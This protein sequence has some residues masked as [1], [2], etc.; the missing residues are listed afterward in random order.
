MP[1]S[2]DVNESSRCPTTPSPDTSVSAPAASAPCPPAGDHVVP[3]SPSRPDIVHDGDF[4]EFITFEFAP[5]PPQDSFAAVN[6]TVS[7]A[8]DPLDDF[9]KTQ[10]FRE[11]GLVDKRG[12]VCVLNL[13][14]TV[15]HAPYCPYTT[16]LDAPCHSPLAVQA[17]SPHQVMVPAVVDQPLSIQSVQQLLDLLV[18][19]TSLPLHAS[20][21]APSADVAHKT[22]CAMAD[23]QAQARQSTPL[24]SPDRGPATLTSSDT[25]IID[26]L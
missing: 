19:S 25:S 4:D 22:T 8:A 2:D 26:W 12:G 7:Q 1:P 23:L 9:L 3:Y 14:C 20:S 21:A 13:D 16:V 24:P 10:H 11:A 5:S 6:N 18:G 15:L 17:A